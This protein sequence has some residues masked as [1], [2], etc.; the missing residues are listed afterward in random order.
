MAIAPLKKLSCCG[1]GADKNR[2]LEALQALGGMHLI[3]GK[4]CGAVADTS[5]LEH[6]RDALKALHYLR[7]CA[8]QRHQVRYDKNFDMSKVVAE[9]LGVQEQIRLFGDKRD[10]LA[11]RIADIEPW[12]NFRLPDAEQLAGLRLWF[13]IVPKSAMAQLRDGEL[14]WYVACQDNLQCY[15]VVVSPSEPPASSMPVARTHTGVVPFS[16]LRAEL[17]QLELE[18]E[19]LQ[20]QRESLTR[21]IWLLNVNL[22]AAENFAQ[23]QYARHCA[24]STGELFLLQGWIAA[25]ETPKFEAF[26]EEQGLAL[27]IEDPVPDEK[28]PTLLTGNGRWAG[29]EDMVRFYQTP[30][31]YGW[32]P[33]QMV[34]FSFAAFF[35]M[36]LSDAGYAAFF[37]A[38]LAL[39]W[40]RMGRSETGS[41]LRMLAAVT[42]GVSL[43]WGVMTAVYFGASPPRESFLGRLRV[44]NIED[45]S[46]MMDIAVGAGVAHITLANLV[47]AWQRRGRR[48]A[49]AALGWAGMAPCGLMIWYA[50]AGGNATLQQAGYGVLGFCVALVVWFSSERPAV[51]GWDYL[52]RL[53]DGIAE[54]FGVSKIFGDVMSYMRLFALGLAG[55]SLA[56]TF[57]KLA[58]E[59]YHAYPGAGLLYALLILLLGHALNIALCIL[60]GVVHGLRL[61]FI[62]FYNW[63]V[64]G[65]GYAF[66]AFCK[67]EVRE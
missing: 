23:L 4:E 45:F 51:K 49:F 20:A 33:S 47:M 44:L 67:K 9:V 19:D 24:R 54:L 32:D 60:S 2:I 6:L 25:A 26:A 10:F 38:L 42:I 62:E 63:S 46:A 36:I 65:E 5:G 37:A 29:G 34:F 22:V 57:N 8:R 31:Y 1:L 18:I 43:L 64:S 15:V 13:Y 3:A 52:R 39:Y 53:A 56:L 66:K 27:L 40:R 50:H 12:G 59:V 58:L 35:A 61:N 7:Q 41:R 17:Q 11:K 28:P 30:D 55:A 48:N 14:V 21:W 16:E